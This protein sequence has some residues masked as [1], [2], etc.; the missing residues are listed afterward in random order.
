MPRRVASG[1]SSSFG[2][3]SRRERREADLFFASLAGGRRAPRAFESED[4]PYDS[5]FK[6]LELSPSSAHGGT[7]MSAGLTL[8]MLTAIMPKLATASAAIQQRY[9]DLTNEMFRLYAIDT[10][11]SRAFFLAHAFV[12]SVQFS[13]MVEADFREAYRE[14][15]RNSEDPAWRP[16]HVTA[17]QRSDYV[18]RGYDKNA[19]IA[20]GGV[21]KY[22]GRGPLQVTTSLGY[23]RALQVMNV[24][25]QEY[26]GTGVIDDSSTLL[27]AVG[28]IGGDPSLAAIPDFAFLLSGAHFKAARRPSSGILRS[29]DK[30]ASSDPPF[31]ADQ[32]LAASASMAGIGSF[33]ELKKWKASAQ[34]II[35]DNLNG[36][37]PVFRRAIQA[38]CGGGT[39]G[40]CAN[41]ALGQAAPRITP[42]LP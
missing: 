5:A 25:G 19:Q 32:F 34:K 22:I 41:P 7:K 27:Q 9:L 28:E 30:S 11:E 39:T 1:G 2:F 42:P 13:A 3:V 6:T 31:R 12:E 24:W 26:G 16:Q 4:A 21:F 15:A 35:A 8:A 40:I 14:R 18:G 38:M 37:M 10:I 17:A 23:R 36:K 20:P 29:M 33:A